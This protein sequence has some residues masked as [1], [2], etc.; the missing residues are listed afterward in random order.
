MKN[1]AIGNR[2]SKEDVLKIF[3]KDFDDMVRRRRIHK[4]E[5]MIGLVKETYKKWVNYCKHR[6]SEEFTHAGLGKEFD[7]QRHFVDE[8][9]TSQF[10]RKEHQKCQR[11]ASK[12]LTE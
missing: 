4:E 7:R 5:G 6:Y 2:M 10:F 9:R 8:M 12:E 3:I 11:S 1:S